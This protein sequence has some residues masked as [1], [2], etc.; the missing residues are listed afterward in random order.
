MTHRDR[1]TRQA[2]KQIQ[3]IVRAAPTT[4]EWDCPL[5]G[6]R[7]Q[8]D[9]ESCAECGGDERRFIRGVTPK[10]LPVFRM[11]YLSRT[12]WTC[13]FCYVVESTTTVDG[14]RQVLFVE[15]NDNTGMSVT[16]AAEDVLTFYAHIFIGGE[17][18]DPDRFQFFEGYEHGGAGGG[19]VDRIVVSG[20]RRI[21]DPHR[22]GALPIRGYPPVSFLAEGVAWKPGTPDDC[23]RFG[24]PDR[25]T[26]TK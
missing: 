12:N 19:G 2:L 6:G 24:F 13:G 21:P 18:F 11:G 4:T 25:G 26:I 14:I 16:N 22:F 15:P 1:A 10:G 5:C 7:W 20:W 23:R 3:D 8:A 9:E 17:R